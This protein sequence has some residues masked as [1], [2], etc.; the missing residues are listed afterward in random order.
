MS[1]LVFCLGLYAMMAAGFTA[2]VAIATETI[3]R[4]TFDD[5]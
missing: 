2:I 4:R 3:N 5:R 1:E